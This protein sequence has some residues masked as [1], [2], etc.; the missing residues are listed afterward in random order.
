MPNELNVEAFEAGE[1]LDKFLVGHLPSLSR[2]RIRKLIDEEQVLVNGRSVAAHRHVKV[3]DRI[4]VLSMDVAVIAQP[5]LRNALHPD[6]LFEDDAVLVIDKPA[7]LIVHPGAGVHEPTLVDWLKQH[8]P[9]IASVGDDPATRPGIVHRLDR[10]VSGVMV[11]AK[12]QAAF[13][14][15][16]QQFKERTIEKE[17]L[18]L[19]HG[20]PKNRSGSI[21]FRIERSKRM[22]GR[23]AARPAGGEGR[24]ARTHY[25]VERVV[26]HNALLRISIDTGRTHQI[27]VHLKALGH[28]II[29]DTFYTT[30]PYRRRASPLHRPFLHSTRLAFTDLNGV[31]REYSA[32]L[33][34]DLRRILAS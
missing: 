2:S 14:R 23:M 11:V 31:R 6:I 10:D 33:P 8:A 9:S 5:M 32:P 34:E 21:D 3:G 25:S 12:T 20:V 24:E 27:R 28:P 16:K 30:K 15:L 19:V 7:G 18:A 17:Y 29:G 4:S 1:R 22:R 26:K 13:E